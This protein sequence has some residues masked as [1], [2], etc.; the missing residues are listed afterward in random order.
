MQEYIETNYETKYLK[1]VYI[2]GDCGAWIKAGVDDNAE[3]HVSHVYPDRLSSRPIVWSE[4]GADA[5]CQFRCYV[6][7]YGEEKVIDL[8]HYCRE[9]KETKAAG[10]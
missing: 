7:D 10:A 9:H 5:M 2:S 6:R 4:T 8:V 1:R 3:G